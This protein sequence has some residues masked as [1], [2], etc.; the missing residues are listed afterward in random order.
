MSKSNTSPT[1]PP[2]SVNS[3][4]STSCTSHSR[5]L[6][7]GETNVASGTDEEDIN[8]MINLKNNLVIHQVK[9]KALKRAFLAEENEDDEAIVVTSC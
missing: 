2:T 1:S 6:L 8:N 4:I 5:D 9:I 7:L 3:E